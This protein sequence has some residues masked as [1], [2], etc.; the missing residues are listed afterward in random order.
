MRSVFKIANLGYPSYQG[1]INNQ[2]VTI[3]E[4]LKFNGYNTYMSGKWHVGAR[5]E[6]RP[7]KRGFDRFFGIVD[8][9]VQ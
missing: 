6:T 2:C 9:G 5:P 3:A 7:R 4:A 1:Y 8:G